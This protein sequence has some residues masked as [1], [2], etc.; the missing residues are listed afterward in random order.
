MSAK[1]LSDMKFIMDFQVQRHWNWKVA[2][3]LYGSG[4]SAGLIFLEVILRNA[5]VIRERTALYGMWIGL[6]LA[7]V[8]LVF[9]FDHLGPQARWRFL[10]VFRRPA[11]SWISRGA[12]IVTVLVLLRLLILLPSVPGFE[13]LPLGENTVG[14]N[15]LRGAVLLFAA[16]FMAYSGLVLSSWN[17]IAFWNSPML[18]TLYIGYSFLAGMAVLPIVAVITG[19]QAE[20]ETIGTVIWPYLLVLLIANGIGLLLYLWGMSSGSLPCRESVRRLLQG[21]QRWSFWAGVVG[22]G[23]L[24]PSIAVALALEGQL[25]SGSTPAVVLVAACLAIQAGGYLL[26][27]TVL[28]VGVYGEPV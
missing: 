7:L 12:L 17:S 8:S 10:Y 13:G 18:P 11:T 24:L 19:G 16:A 14:G 2:F 3:Y 1:G 20:L 21:E 26:R 6:S 15:A 4:T 28:Q 27:D 5:D 9:L 23:L 22:I 25:G